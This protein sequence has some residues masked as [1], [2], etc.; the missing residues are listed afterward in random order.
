[1]RVKRRR[2]R[3]TSRARIAGEQGSLCDPFSRRRALPPSRL[4]QADTRTHPRGR[5]GC[6]G[7]MSPAQSCVDRLIS[8]FPEVLRTQGETRVLCCIDIDCETLFLSPSSPYFLHCVPCDFLGD[9]RAQQWEIRA[10]SLVVYIRLLT[11]V[12]AVLSMR[13]HTCLLVREV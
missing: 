7:G 11:R 9:P 6:G 8:G 10:F 2:A 13:I 1:M 12:D 3:T 4:V 5:K